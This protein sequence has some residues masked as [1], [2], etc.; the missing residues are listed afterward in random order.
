MGLHRGREASTSTRVGQ[1]LQQMMREVVDDAT[2]LMQET[3]RWKVPRLDL[4][5]RM[6]LVEVES[7]G[8]R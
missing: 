8:L 7:G 4:E 5:G 2:R 3:V 6:N 1:Q